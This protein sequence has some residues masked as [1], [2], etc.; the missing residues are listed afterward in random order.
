M[1]FRARLSTLLIQDPQEAETIQL[2]LKAHSLWL[3]TQLLPMLLNPLQGWLQVVCMDLQSQ[4][5]YF[6]A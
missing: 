5:M 1:C 4:N 6:R 2:E 3:L